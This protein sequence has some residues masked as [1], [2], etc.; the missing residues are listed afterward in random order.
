MK[1]R[2][3]KT[4]EIGNLMSMNWNENSLKVLDEN[5]IQLAKYNCFSE[6]IDEWEDYEE[7][8]EIEEL[9]K[10]HDSLKKELEKYEE[11]YEKR[12]NEVCTRLLTIRNNCPDDTYAKWLLDAINFIQE[13]ER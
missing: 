5:G 10:L 9:N 1:L 13:E 6:L 8:R 4:G 7:P 11:W 12:K 3:K 2:N